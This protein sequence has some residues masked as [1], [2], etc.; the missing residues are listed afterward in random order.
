MNGFRCNVTG[1][2]SNVA[3]ATPQVARRCGADPANDKM[4]AAPGNCT[5]GAK[6]P[7]YWFQKERNNVSPISYQ[8]RLTCSNHMKSRC[9]RAPTRH[10]STLICT[11][12][13]TAHRTTF[14]WTRTRVD[15]RLPVLTRPSSL[16][17]SSATR[18]PRARL[19]QD[20]RHP[21][22]TARPTRTPQVPRQAQL[23]P[24]PLLPLHHLRFRQQRLLHHNRQLTRLSQSV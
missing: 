24:A 12:T 23:Q 13:R 9:S 14:S 5:Y 19:P 22:L 15:S 20:H 18:R 8:N 21:L 11:T 4:Q 2:T 17:R 6:Q 7:L 3:L 1:S 16:P 10:L